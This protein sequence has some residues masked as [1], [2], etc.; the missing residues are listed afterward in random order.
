MKII[1][2]IIMIYYEY[3]HGNIVLS[4]HILQYL[5]GYYIINTILLYYVDN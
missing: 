4:Y 2:S 1:M 5:N 3:H